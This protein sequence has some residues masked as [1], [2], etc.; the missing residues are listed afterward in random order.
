MER[1]IGVLKSR[2]RC[3]LGARELHYQ[4]NKAK[5]II[6]ACCALHNMCRYYIV[7]SPEDEVFDSDNLVSEVYSEPAEVNTSLLQ[8][9]QRIRNEIMNS[10]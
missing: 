7:D 10:L 6:N 1:T 3:L 9:G 2:F 5:Q 4:P 8:E